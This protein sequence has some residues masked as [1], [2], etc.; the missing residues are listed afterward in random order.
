MHTP[1]Y[2]RWEMK[3]LVEILIN[4]SSG[5]RIAIYSQDGY[6]LGH[7]RRTSA[8]AHQLIHQ[9]PDVSVLTLSDSPHG[10]FF[11]TAPNHDYIKLP[12]IAKSGPGEWH[13]SRLLI[14]FQEVKE[15][16]QQLI[17]S[18][19][20]GYAPDLLLV[21]HMP[22]GAMGELLP[23]LRAIRAAGLPTKIVLGLRDILDAP[24]VVEARWQ[25]E[26][27][28]DI[29]DAYYTRVLIYGQRD[30]YDAAEQYRFPDPIC[31][32]VRYCGYVVNL[33]HPT[34]NAELRARFLAGTPAGTRLVLA[35]A[36]GGADAYPL[37][38]AL[39]EAYSGT[40]KDLHAVLVIVTGPFMPPDLVADLH[41]RASSTPAHI[42]ESVDDSLNYTA[43]ADLVIAMA[44]YNTTVEILRMRKPAILVPRKGP[45]AEQRTR[46][47]LFADRRWV[48][49]ID[50]AALTPEIL[51]QKM[52]RRLKMPDEHR[53][54]GHPGLYGALVAANHLSAL[55]PQPVWV[56]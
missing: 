20:L 47:R 48:D 9:R 46:A 34:R 10:Q 53:Q 30:I 42:L 35:M 11:P 1:I 25:A 37:M 28:Y 33:E 13:A 56:S 15:L 4:H 41:R 40:L 49:M 16:R 22:H 8:I 43:A 23:A 6:G 26:G 45:S 18:T 50:P 39:L 7:M 54:N 31:E 2:D 17:E 21:D 55:L 51:A 19:L 5:P 29:L 32:R 27:A 3:A 52:L 36:G 24:E 14:T 12:S 38:S 44:G